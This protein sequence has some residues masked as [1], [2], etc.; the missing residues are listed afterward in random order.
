MRLLP[1]YDLVNYVQAEFRF[2]RAYQ[3]L[4]ADYYIIKYRQKDS[5]EV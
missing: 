3:I 1:I 2:W 4:L 5:M